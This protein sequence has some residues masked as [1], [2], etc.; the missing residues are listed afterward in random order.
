MKAI[1]NILISSMVVLT[2][3]A[4]AQAETTSTY[5][6]YDANA[7]ATVDM[8]EFSTAFG[9]GLYD[10]FD[11]DASGAVDQ[12]E[13]GQGLFGVFDANGDGVLSQEE[14]QAGADLW[15]KQSGSAMADS[16]GMSFDDLDADAS[17]TL[18]ED[19]Y[20]V[21]PASATMDFGSIDA[22]VSGDVSREE[23]DASM[24]GG[25][26]GDTS[27]DTAMTPAFGDLDA[28]ASGD[29]STEE[30]TAAYDTTS[31]F[32]SF[33]TDASSDLSQDEFNQGVFTL[34]DRNA[35]QMIGEDEFV[36][37]EGLFRDHTATGEGN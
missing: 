21:D 23:F 17:G 14:Y 18:S 31:A 26:S 22:D 28:D 32:G 16:Q 9:S 15:T 5:S 4:L 24:G 27:A 8:G 13:F 19:E 33:D 10:R 7:D 6:D 12:T 2:G 11:L 1:R 30:F 36:S 3:A 34:A 20:A 25:M 35:D 29:L 37:S